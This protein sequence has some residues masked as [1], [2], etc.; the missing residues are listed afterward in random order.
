MADADASLRLTEEDDVGRE[1]EVLVVFH[2]VAPEKLGRLRDR[3]VAT[4][5]P[6]SDEDYVVDQSRTEERLSQVAHRVWLSGVNH[7]GKVC[8]EYDRTNDAAF[9]YPPGSFLCGN[10]KAER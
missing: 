3:V 10:F 6:R 1:N 4:G 7:R 9:R 5:V 8:A 2:R